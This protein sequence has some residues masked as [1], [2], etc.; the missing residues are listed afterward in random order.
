MLPTCKPPGPP[1]SQQHDGLRTAHT[2]STFSTP[3]T[4][5][6]SSTRPA[7]THS[8]AAHVPKAALR[9]HGEHKPPRGV[10]SRSPAG[11]ARTGGLTALCPQVDCP[12]GDLDPGSSGS[13]RSLTSQLSA[14]GLPCT[15]PPTPSANARIP[16]SSFNQESAPT[17]RERKQCGGCT[18]FTVK[19]ELLPKDALLTVTAH[20]EGGSLGKGVP[21]GVLCSY[22][23][24]AGFCSAGRGQVMISS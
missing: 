16:G 21:L 11:S 9:D 15:F 3:F 2:F 22:G 18:E 6:A 20:G 23:P 12:L 7:L 4:A 17:T 10:C 8:H 13:W 14:S 24:D 1:T 19:L 5:P